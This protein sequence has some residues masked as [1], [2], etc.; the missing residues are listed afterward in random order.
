MRKGHLSEFFSG[1]AMKTLSTVETDPVRS[2][3]HEFNG[4]EALKDLFGIATDKE[5]F[6]TR[7]IYL[8]DE[9]TSMPVTSEGILTWYDA[10]ASHPTRSEH[11]LYFSSTPV[12]EYAQAGDLMIIGKQQDGPVLVIV[13][14]AGS[15]IANQLKWLFGFSDIKH[16]GF[17]IKAETESDQ[18]KLEFA[19]KFI[20]EQI[21]ITSHDITTDF[22]DIMLQKFGGNFP[23]TRI[24][25]EFARS[26]LPTLDSRDDPDH[27]LMS[28][29]ERE[30]QL[31]RTLER[32]IVAA[33][34]IDGFEDNVDE[35]ISF[36]L[37]V[38]NRRK[39]RVGYALEN[40][41]EEI[42]IREYI[43]YDRTAVT[44]NNSKPD[45]IFPGIMQ[46]RNPYFDNN[47][48]TILGVK[49]TCKD[50]W[51]QVLSEADRITNKHLL[52]LEPGISIAQT[53]EMRDKKLTLVL[54]KALHSSYT[55]DQQ[56][57]M[58]DLYDFICLVK[59][60]ES[61]R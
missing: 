44:E 53:N 31:F 46:Y 57:W 16:S 20:L 43:Q 47:N 38:Q 40:H 27:I 37:S 48:L 33:R 6:Y 21:G 17:S 7:F 60:R 9:N 52:T 42:F 3:Q 30:E 58:L 18:I 55:T 14:E 2:N 15:T 32:H 49:S 61:L 12:S 51:R 13:A 23:T 59:T 39:S 28:W 29:M 45:F 22:L 4:V 54:P 35:F 26:T 25:S 8:T 34:L 11:R 36:S 50:R 10:R 1:V 41:L 56:A 24:F 19:S 5:R